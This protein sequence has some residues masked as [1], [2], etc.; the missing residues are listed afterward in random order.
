MNEF[1]SPYIEGQVIPPEEGAPS[2]HGFESPQPLS[3]PEKKI[4][5]C[6]KSASEC[7]QKT[8]QL[9]HEFNHGTYCAAHLVL[10]MTLVPNATRQFDLRKV[11]IDKA[12]RA[13]MHALIEMERGSP[14]HRTVPRPS[15][16]LS[17]IVSLAEEVAKNRDNQ[18][19]SVDDLL[20]A[21]DRMPP[22]TSA[23]QLL[24]GERKGIPD[25]MI[26][27][28]LLDLADSV[29]TQLRALE[30]EIRNLEQEVRST[31]AAS[32]LRYELNEM[33]S[34]MTR[35]GGELDRKLGEIF[36]QLALRAEPAAQPAAIP[37]SPPPPRTG[38]WDRLTSA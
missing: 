29:S 3:V 28:S 9:A 36:V 38:I 21:V 24:R 35:Q 16:E 31:S 18:E 30:Q 27:Q 15:E 12:F 8:K 22:E 19:V 2:L 1:H 11:D 23:A 17:M 33:K 26:R 37:E 10:A 4:Q 34:E 14:N 5:G 7:L 13:S 6:S 32:S 20:T 25:T